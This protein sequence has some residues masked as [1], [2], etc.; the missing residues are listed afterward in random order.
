MEGNVVG[1]EKQKI[2]LLNHNEVF[3]GVAVELAR[4]RF[5]IVCVGK[6]RAK[7]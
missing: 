2:V 1:R 3:Y 5:V 6:A 4:T 7:H